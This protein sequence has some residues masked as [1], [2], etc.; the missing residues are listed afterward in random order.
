[1]ARNELKYMEAAIA[2]AE[3]LSFSRAAK[4]LH[5]SQPA[6]TKHIAELE[7][8][9]G[10]V[11]FIRDHHVVSLTDAGRAY[12]KEARI[13]VL[14]AE[15]AVQAARAAGQDTEMILNIGRT[16]YADPFFTSTILATRLPLFPRLRLNLSSGFSCDL[17]HE[18]LTGELDLALV[19]EPPDS[20]LLTGL[21]ID[22]SP[23]YVVMS[24]DDE[25]ANYPSLS[26]DQLAGKRWVLFQRHSHPPLYDLIRKLAQE[27]RIIPSGIQHFMVPEEAIPLLNEPGGLVIVAK[28]GALRIAR[29]GLTMRPLDETRLMM[30]TLLI[31]RADNG[32]QVV[33]ELVRSF[34][35]RMNHLKVEDQM[36]LPIPV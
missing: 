26:L 29:A 15:R 33:S 7:E 27:L 11:L 31:S 10:V 3:E 21:K 20:G 17:A 32:S 24:Q 1:M 8:A 36:L 22:E 19:I 30:N 34:M 35:R 18:V 2:V 14:H 4:R 23:F 16:P 25:L 28:S 13:S 5:L 6:V 9:L 12:V